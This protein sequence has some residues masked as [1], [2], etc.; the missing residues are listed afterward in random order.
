MDEAT[1][2]MANE[3]T[4]L[5]Q[6]AERVLSLDPTSTESFLS[7]VTEYLEDFDRWAA[8]MSATGAPSEPLRGALEQLSG[9]HQQVTERA[10]L[11]REKIKWDLGETHRRAQGLKAYVDRFPS[12]ITIAGKREG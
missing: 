1:L 4:H 5:K 2:K 9:L 12:R 7:L 11:H 10:D 6:L 8:A 3:I